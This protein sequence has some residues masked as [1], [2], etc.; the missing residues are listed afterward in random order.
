ME[1]QQ[2]VVLSFLK[3]AA[4]LKGRGIAAAAAI[5]SKTGAESVAFDPSGKYLAS[6]CRDD[7]VR[8]WDVST[9]Q[10]VAELRGHTRAVT[11]VAFDSSGKYLASGSDDYTV[12]VWDV[13][14]GKE[15]AELEISADG[16]RF[17]L[18]QLSVAF[19]PSGRYLALGYSRTVI[20]CDVAARQQV[21]ELRGHTGTVTSVAF[22]P[23]GRYLASGCDD[24]T[25]RVWDVSSMQQVAVLAGS[26]ETSYVT[27]VAFDPSGKYLASAIHESDWWNRTI[28]MVWDVAFPSAPALDELAFDA[29]GYDM[30]TRGPELRPILSRN[31]RNG[32]G[33][34]GRRSRKKNNRNK[35]RVKTL[36]NKKKYRSPRARRFRS[37]N[38]K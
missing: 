20:M 16:G 5:G 10:Q 7:T 33:Q 12:R 34:G 14:A 2:P 11:S 27:S 9:W 26:H 38:K 4:E 15:V 29:L 24:K 3:V 13:V 8:V 21:A 23:S 31:Q 32:Q 28:V 25:V 35:K 19:D 37:K 36:K 18:A 1:L 22:D 30:A 6:G 17:H